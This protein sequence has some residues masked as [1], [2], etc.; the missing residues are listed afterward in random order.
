VKLT[1]RKVIA[2]GVAL[3]VLAA[4]ASKPPAPAARA[5]VALTPP[6]ESSTRTSAP[7]PTLTV[8]P[9]QTSRPTSTAAPIVS[10]TLTPT[11]LPTQS[12]TAT[13]P[14]PTRTRAPERTPMPITIVPTDTVAPPANCVPSYPTVCIPPPP[15]DL[16]CGDIPYRRFTVL[17]PDPHN[18]DRDGDGVGCES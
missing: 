4:L 12:P 17:P 8:R 7:N 14:A 6:A 9:T 11:Q 13:S 3:V 18:F 2:S 10:L 5:P 1:R 15:P 16:D